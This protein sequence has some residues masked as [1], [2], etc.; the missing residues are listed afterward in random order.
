MDEDLAEV[1]MIEEDTLTED[2]SDDALEAM[3]ST[4]KI[5]LTLSYVPLYCRLC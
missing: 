2:V 5:T 1:G 3:A 4:T